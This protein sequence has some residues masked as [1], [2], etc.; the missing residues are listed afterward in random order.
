MIKP[1]L[2]CA[3]A[4]LAGAMALA[5][6]PVHAVSLVAGSD[7]GAIV[8]GVSPYGGAPNVGNPTYI[9]NNVNG[10]NDVL[11]SPGLGSL[12]GYLTANPVAA[13]NIVQV[14]GPLPGALQQWAGFNA[15]GAFG[16]GSI[17]LTATQV[18]FGIVDTAA[19]GGSASYGIATWEA[20]FEQLKA[21]YVG[22]F[23]NWLGITGVVSQPG[24][25]AV[26]S[27]RTYIESANPAS[28]FFGG[29]DLAPLV[30]AASNN[31][32]PGMNLVARG[33]QALTVGVPALGLYKGLA[34]NSLNV[35]IPVGDSFVVKSTLTIYADPA[36]MQSVSPLTL[37]SVFND[38]GFAGFVLP[39]AIAAGMDSAP[40]QPVPEPSTTLMLALGLGLCCC[41]ARQR[42]AG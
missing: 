9:G 26:A 30:L 6:A 38:A 24:N 36:S 21:P 33:T 39:D 18:G 35:N 16:T 31:G 34:I 40:S 8:F 5:A 41:R 14:G 7:S 10:R 23:G 20:T 3:L 32:A 28:P 11:A 27:L 12:G 2:A 15:F 42:R 1:R 37:G 19:G 4:A 22:T 25:A 17:A 29:V 13:N